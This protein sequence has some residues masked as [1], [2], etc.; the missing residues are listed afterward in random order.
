MNIIEDIRQRAGLSEST[1]RNAADD[2]AALFKTL[3]SFGYSRPKLAWKKMPD[4]GYRITGHAYTRDA[5]FNDVQIE[6][7]DTVVSR[8]ANAHKWTRK[9]RSGGPGRNREILFSRDSSSVRMVIGAGGQ[10]RNAIH[11]YLDYFTR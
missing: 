3:Q 9:E 1:E 11:F 7:M 8:W 5:G 10:R 4:G 6:G 2:I